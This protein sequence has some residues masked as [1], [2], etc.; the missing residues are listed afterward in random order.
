[1]CYPFSLLF[2]LWFLFFGCLIV[3]CFCFVLFICF[4]ITKSGATL[5]QPSTPKCQVEQGDY[6]NCPIFKAPIY[7]SQYDVYLFCTMLIH[8]LFSST[9]TLRLLSAQLL[10]NQSSPF[11][12]LFPVRC[13][14]CVCL[15]RTELAEKRKVR[16]FSHICQG[17]SEA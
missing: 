17:C 8:V 3:L 7:M 5:G 14:A 9:V 11:L 6:S 12:H 2:L 4:Q 10:P 15:C 13:M 1:M 16:W